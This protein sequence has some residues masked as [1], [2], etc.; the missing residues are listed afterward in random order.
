M[1]HYLY[2]CRHRGEKHHYGPH[3]AKTLDD[4][5]SALC[6]AFELSDAQAQVL[7]RDYHVRF[8]PDGSTEYCEITV[9]TCDQPWEHETD[10]DS[11]LRRREGWE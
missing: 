3:V 7:R 2:A 8:R 11:P 9:C 6:Y 5:V 10:P 1:A 4:A